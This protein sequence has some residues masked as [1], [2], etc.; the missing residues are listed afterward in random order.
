MQSDMFPNEIAAL[1]Q[2]R[3]VTKNCPL[4]VL[5]PYMNEDK[6]I[7]IRR[8][9]RRACLPE[10]M[11]N[12]V[13]LRAHALLELIIQHH[14][15]TTL[16]A[17]SQLTLASLRHEAWILRATVLYKCIPC[18]R[19]RADVPVE[20]MGDLPAARINRTA[21]AFVY[22]GVDYAGP[23]AVHT[24]PSQG[25]KSQKAYI[26]LFVCLT[27]KAL[28]LELISDYTSTTFIVAYQR[29]ILRRGLSTSMYSDNGTTFHGA[30]RELSNAHAKAIRNPNF[31]NR[32][33]ID[34]TA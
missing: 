16:H 8:R 22:T 31:R 28:H 27:T 12:S 5:N 32:L 23:I 29:L 24:T 26:A 3:L 9:L 30:D 33:T 17:G 10:A 2:K 13:V 15:L 34:G 18:T 7:R 21:R 14:H 4:S 19:D 1:K 11:K 20:L 25:N 6:L